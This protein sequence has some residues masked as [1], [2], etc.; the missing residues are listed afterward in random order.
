[1]LISQP[2]QWWL[3]VG[4]YTVDFIRIDAYAIRTQW[5]MRN[6]MDPSLKESAWRELDYLGRIKVVLMCLFFLGAVAFAVQ[7]CEYVSL[8]VKR[9]P[10]N[11]VN[12]D[13]MNG[14]C[15]VGILA[16]LQNL[17]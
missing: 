5:K 1:M 9:S 15:G 8:P 12:V 6:I 17:T 16:L 10:M 7:I 11:V 13:G 3:G 14:T 4:A 2:G